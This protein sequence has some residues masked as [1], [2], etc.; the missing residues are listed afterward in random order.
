MLEHPPR[1]G[2]VIDYQAHGAG[3]VH[4]DRGQRFDVDAECR[5]P[6][7][8]VRQ[9]SGTV[10]QVDR[11]LGHTRTIRQSWSVRAAAVMLAALAVVACG[12]SR[13]AATTSAPGCAHVVAVD[14]EPSPP[15]GFA[16][17]VTVRSDDVGW[18]GYADRWEVVL[19]GAVVGERILTHPHVEEQ[20]FTRSQSG[21]QVPSGSEVAVRAHHTVGGWCGATMTVRVPG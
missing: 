17:A 19:D 18:D 21:I 9:R 14:V 4:S 20:P 16:F 3:V 13:P 2:H 1:R 15:S 5:D 10:G 7:R 12:G 8:Q 6:L 11:E